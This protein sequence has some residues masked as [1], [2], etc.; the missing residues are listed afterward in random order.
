M[1]WVAPVGKWTDKVSRVAVQAM[2]TARLTSHMS[3]LNTSILA[4]K[5][6]V[7]ICYCIYLKS[8]Q[9][10][11]QWL[12]VYTFPYRKGKYFYF[13]LT[14]TIP[15][16]SWIKVISRIVHESL[17]IRLPVHAEHPFFFPFY[18]SCTCNTRKLVNI[19]PNRKYN[20]VLWTFLGLISFSVDKVK[21]HFLKNNL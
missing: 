11:K 1:L 7:I 20:R 16:I 4:T 12:Q 14:L 9:I 13:C 18:P 15:I 8:V 3:M 2:E 21:L 5:G 10:S 6:Q 19:H 17:S